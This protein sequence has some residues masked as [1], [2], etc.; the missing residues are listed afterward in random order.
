MTPLL[1]QF[2]A[3]ITVFV[4]TVTSCISCT[5]VSTR[6]TIVVEIPA[7]PKLFPSV[8]RVA[9]IPTSLENPRVTVATAWAIDKDHLMTAGHFCESAHELKTLGYADDILW[10][11]GVDVQG[12]PTINFPGKVKAWVNK[13]MNDMC[14]IESFGHP[15]LPLELETDLSLVQAEDPIITLGAPR[16]YFMIRRDG[17]V[18]A[19]VED[20]IMLAI[21]VQSG[22][23]GGPIIW[24]GKVIGM[25]VLS[26]PGLNETGIAVR[27]DNLK[28]FLDEHL[29]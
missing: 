24:Q 13:D 1:H 28:R 22:N 10:L 27:S 12:K 19:V 25:I 4:S 8:A 15:L 20:G 2:L 11:T 9:T 23:S 29:L 6:R 18:W 14:I 26:I 5:P 16:G 7:S 17:Y 3:L 21:E